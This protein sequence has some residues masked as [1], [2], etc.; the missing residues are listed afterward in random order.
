MRRLAVVLALGAL[1]CAAATPALA[2][3]GVAEVGG[4]VLDE[5]GGALPGV[6]VVVTNQD[7]GIFREVIT[8]GDGSYFAAQLIPGTYMVAAELPGFSRFE[9]RD[10]ILGV[11]RT[12]TIDMTLQVGALEETITVTGESPLIDLTSAEVGGNVGVDEMVELPSLGRNF[13]QFIGLMPGIQPTATSG[14]FGCETVLSNG[15]SSRNNNVVMD[16]GTNMDDYLGSGC[17]AQTRVPIESI[18]EFQ[19]LTN[20]YDAEFGRTAGA[21]INA[22][23][24]QGTKQFSGSAFLFDTRS[25]I[26]ARNFFTEEADREK[27][28]TNKIEWGATLG[29]PIVPNKAHFFASVERVHRNDGRTNSLSDPTGPHLDGPRQDPG[30]ELDFPHGSSDQ[31]EQH[32]GLPLGARVF[33]AGGHDDQPGHARDAASGSRLGS[34]HRRQPHLGD[35]Q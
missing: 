3:Q 15:G 13:F 23:T 28:D 6:T 11:G 16:G 25:A 24:K 7:T 2:Q 1:L 22:I 14:S 9:R 35:R 8:T 33:A 27:P 17:G 34:H 32:L 31:R 5:Q 21:I 4:R 29:G 20:Q 12:V 18:Q 10:L 26:T 19:V 30:V